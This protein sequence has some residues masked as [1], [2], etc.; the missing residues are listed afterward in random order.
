MR[1]VVALALSI[2]LLAAPA[3]A[4]GWSP[5]RGSAEPYADTPN[6]A[7]LKGIEIETAEGRERLAELAQ[8]GNPLAMLGLGL[9]YAEGKVFP[10]D[11]ELAKLWL[12][13]AAVGAAT[14]SVS[15]E[16]RNDVSQLVEMFR[17]DPEI[18]LPKVCPL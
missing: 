16:I 7:E 17:T 15:T 5:G 14:W 13:R 11:C 18:G 12:D 1:T 9:A 3:V 2:L 6:Y 10:R 8:G 4:D